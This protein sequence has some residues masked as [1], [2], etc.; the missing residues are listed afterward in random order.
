MASAVHVGGLEYAKQSREGC[1]AVTVACAIAR[2]RPFIQRGKCH[3]AANAEISCHRAGG[4]LL[5]QRAGG[6]LRGRRGCARS[7]N[8]QTEYPRPTPVSPSTK[9]RANA[10]NDAGG[11]NKAE[12]PGRTRWLEICVVGKHGTKAPFNTC[13]I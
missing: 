10:T 1:P 2:A 13:D 12:P 7:G 8:A 11:L 9:F 4:A 6:A 3:H 5:G